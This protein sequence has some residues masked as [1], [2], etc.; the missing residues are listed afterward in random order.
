MGLT[1]FLNGLL[2]CIQLR[3]VGK[4]QALQY[5]QRTIYQQPIHQLLY[6]NMG[7]NFRRHMQLQKLFLAVS[8][9]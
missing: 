1:N 5:I 9:Y 6:A 4:L 3:F 7:Y 2:F 8:D